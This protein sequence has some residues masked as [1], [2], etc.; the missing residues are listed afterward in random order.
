MS[1]QT[2]EQGKQLI[3]DALTEYKLFGTDDIYVQYRD[4]LEDERLIYYVY[5]RMSSIENSQVLSVSLSP[6]VNVQVL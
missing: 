2:I 5:L 4:E 1:E 6:V 3:I